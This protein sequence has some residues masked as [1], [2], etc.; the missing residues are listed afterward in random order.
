MQRFSVSSVS[1]FHQILLHFGFWTQVQ[2]TLSDFSFLD[3]D[4][5]FLEYCNPLIQLIGS[6]FG[7]KLSWQI[8][9]PHIQTLSSPESY[10]PCQLQTLFSGYLQDYSLSYCSNYPMGS[11]V[12]ECSPHLPLVPVSF[13]WA[14]NLAAL[15]TSVPPMG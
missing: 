5:I 6:M 9:S 8:Y 14:V 12:D 1:L 7:L 15:A 10:S 4:R 11:L 3:C 2:L 13:P